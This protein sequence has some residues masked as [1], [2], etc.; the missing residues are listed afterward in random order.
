[1][2]LAQALPQDPGQALAQALALDQDPVQALVPFPV[3][4][5]LTL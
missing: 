3:I 4:F 1:M 5:L 2:D